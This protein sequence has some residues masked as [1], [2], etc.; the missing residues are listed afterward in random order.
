MKTRLRIDPSTVGE[1][2]LVSTAEAE[3]WGV[4]RHDLAILVR[5]GLV[6]RV[7]RGWYS[8]RMD[9]TEEECHVLRTVAHLR[10][11]GEHSVACRHSAV[12]LHGLPLARADLSVVEIAKVNATHGRTGRGVRVSDLGAQRE[13]CAEIFVPIADM[14]V[15]VVDPATAIVGTA[16]TNNP[17]AALVAG[18]H[19]LRYGLCTRAALEEV[20]DEGRRTTGIGRAREVVKHLDP[21]HESPGETLTAAIL[22]R[23]RWELDPQ[24]EVRARGRRYRLDFALRDHRVAIEFDG[25]IKY[26]GPEVMAAQ[27][28]READLRSDGWIVVRFTWDDLED[29][30]EMFARLD[31][32]VQQATASP[33]A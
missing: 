22:R 28:A 29:E 26:T 30:G 8:S 18:D 13:D 11:H 2:P 15:R 14:S 25:A 3:D 6:W 10:L 5:R 1:L 21:R 31:A 12:L 32:A 7:A 27:V 9:A 16:R 17:V 23:G 19:A 20:L 24:V 4:S 33:S